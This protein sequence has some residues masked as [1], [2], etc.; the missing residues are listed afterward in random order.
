MRCTVITHLLKPLILLSVLP[1]GKVHFY[2]NVT[3]YT[4]IICLPRTNVYSACHVWIAFCFS[5]H[6]SFLSIS[7]FQ[8]TL[9]KPSFSSERCQLVTCRLWIVNYEDDELTRI[10]LWI[11]VYWYYA[12]LGD[13]GSV[14]VLVRSRVR[15]YFFGTN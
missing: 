15:V 2:V 5:V 9:S 7:I 3:I 11:N 14:T 10:Q 6:K 1:T 4:F 13:C 8:R 12:V